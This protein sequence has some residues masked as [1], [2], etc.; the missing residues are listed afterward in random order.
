MESIVLEAA[1]GL[2]RLADTNDH[3]VDFAGLQLFHRDS[4][5]DIDDL[6]F[7]PESLEHGQ[8]GD[9]SAAIGKVD[10]DGLAIEIPETADRFRRDDMHLFVVELGDVGELLLDVLGEALP[11]EI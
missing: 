4:L 1:H 3:G 6:W 2:I 11:L 10:T 5:F 8:R 7:H 9:E